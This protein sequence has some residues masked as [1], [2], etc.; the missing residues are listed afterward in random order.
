[1]KLGQ[2]WIDSIAEGINQYE[3]STNRI[4]LVPTGGLRDIPDAD[5]NN[6]IYCIDSGFEIIW[7][8]S[9]S[10]PPKFETDAFVSL[11]LSGS[12]LLADRFFGDEFEIDRASGKAVAI[13][14]HK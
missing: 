3:K 7:Q 13:G 9:P 4:V 10:L 5:K 6:N 8:I 12:R 11:R 14:W 1:M 2:K